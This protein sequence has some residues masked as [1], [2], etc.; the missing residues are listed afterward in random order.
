[1]SG[2]IRGRGWTGAAP[3]DLECAWQRQRPRLGSQSLRRGS[4][5]ATGSGEG[6]AT[7]NASN[8]KTPTAA[9]QQKLMLLLHREHQT[10]KNGRQPP[11][12]TKAHFFTRHV[13][14]AAER[15][16]RVGGGDRADGI[17]AGEAELGNHQKCEHRE[18]APPREPPPTAVTGGRRAERRPPQRLAP[19]RPAGAAETHLVRPGAFA[20]RG[21]AQRVSAESRHRCKSNSRLSITQSCLHLMGSY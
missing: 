20:A 5:S 21:R 17:S 2:K 7:K 6:L 1:M 10:L 15:C 12:R 8:A 9:K 13:S 18:P 11:S 16:Q 4:V 14:E 19:G 3:L